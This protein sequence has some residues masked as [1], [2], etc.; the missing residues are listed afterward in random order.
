MANSGIVELLLAKEGID[1]NAQDEDGETA[2]MIA[3]QWDKS[4]VVKLL[5]AK[6]GIDVNAQDTYGFTAHGPNRHRRRQ[7]RQSK[8]SL[9]PSLAVRFCIL[10]FVAAV[11]VGV[12]DADRRRRNGRGRGA[13]GETG[14]RRW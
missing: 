12:L 11:V 10:D 6:D 5:L 2:L 9:P 8:T 13:A 7:R 1:V 3:S 4:E 14:G